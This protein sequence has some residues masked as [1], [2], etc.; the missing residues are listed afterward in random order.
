MQPEMPTHELLLL[1]FT[2]YL[3]DSLASFF[4]SALVIPKYCEGNG[5]LAVLA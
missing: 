1:L 2:F 4:M 3:Q 5:V